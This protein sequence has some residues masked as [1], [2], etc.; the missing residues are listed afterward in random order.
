MGYFFAAP[1]KNARIPAD[2]NWISVKSEGNMKLP[3][4]QTTYKPNSTN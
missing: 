4:E 3:K 2:K 1:G